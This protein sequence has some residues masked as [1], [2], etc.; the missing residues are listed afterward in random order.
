M[1]SQTT[2]GWAN[3]VGNSARKNIAHNLSSCGQLERIFMGG[4]KARAAAQLFSNQKVESKRPRLDLRTI[5]RAYFL[6]FLGRNIFIVQEVSMKASAMDDVEE[7]IKAQ[8]QI[9]DYDIKEY[10]IEVLVSKYSTK[11][12]ENENEIYVPPYQRDFVW[13]EDRQSKFIESILLG[14]PIPYIFTAEND[15]DGRLE[16]IDGSQRIRTLHRFLKGELWLSK[17]EILTECNGLNFKD[18]PESRQRKIHNSSLRM[19]VLSSKSDDDSR[20]M[21]FERINTGSDL[22]NAM[23]RRRGIIQG[24]FTDFL[25]KCASDAEFQSL[26]RFT[27]T[28]RKRRE[29]EELVLRFFA[30]FEK[31][32]DYKGNL[33]KFLSDYLV[34]K[35]K[36]RFNKDTH[37]KTFKNMLKYVH[38][39]FKNGFLKAES[40]YSTPRAR[41]EA[42]SVG[43]A[44][45]QAE[46][47]KLS[48]KNMKWAS[49]EEF[50][51]L[52]SGTSLNKASKM[53]ARINY[54]KEQV[55]KV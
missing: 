23:E 46:G 20:F 11:L 18:F 55:L 52:T 53:L 9:V 48:S 47:K 12:E 2:S 25:S 33:D 15:L 37:F 7:Q 32:K 26:T 30:F 40:H 19:I 17:L 14:L 21:L 41:F 38:K 54:V 35:N 5:L 36:K 13:D 49:G 51:L 6:N 44:L 31:L 45:A 34:V 10:P 29:P 22:L 16:I 24:P 27:E 8:Q 3:V 1:P 39:N 42:I 28:S 4:E 50:M 43:V